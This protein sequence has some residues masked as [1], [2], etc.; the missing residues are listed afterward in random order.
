MVLW[1]NQD[2]LTALT[3]YLTKKVFFTFQK[4]D[5]YPVVTFLVLS[6]QKHIVENT[7]KQI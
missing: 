5:F 4:S 7:I 3:L 6:E 2:T 1:P